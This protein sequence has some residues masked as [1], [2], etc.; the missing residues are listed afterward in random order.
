V[1]EAWLEGCGHLPMLE[2]PTRVA[3]I[4]AEAIAASRAP[5]AAAA[6]RAWR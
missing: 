5:A 6:R 3:D 1:R 4:I 2:D